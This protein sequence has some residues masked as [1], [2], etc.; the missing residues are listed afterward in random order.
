MIL[1]KFCYW[2]RTMLYISLIWFSYLRL[3]TT[4]LW[5][6]SILN[7][8]KVIRADNLSVLKGGDVCTYI[9]ESLPIK[10]LNT[11]NLH[12]CLWIFLNGLR[13]CIGSLYQPPSQSSDGHDHFIKTFEK[14]I[15]HL[16][17]F[18]P[19]FLLSTLL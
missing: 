13:S 15:V 18:K 10:V 16:N 5:R 6:Q 11:T 1:F 17:S 9:K 2:K 19:Q 3:S 7:E 8:Y 12:E 4:V 14:L